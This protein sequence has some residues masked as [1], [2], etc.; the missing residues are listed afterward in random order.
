MTS[1]TETGINSSSCA[2]VRNSV[3][4]FLAILA[5]AAGLSWLLYEPVFPSDY[6]TVLYD[7]IFS[8]VLWIR[9]VVPPLAVALMIIAMLVFT[10]GYDGLVPS[11]KDVRIYT[12]TLS[13]SVVW[14]LLAG[15]FLASSMTKTGLDADLIAFSMR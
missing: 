8:I 9:Y 1:V 15:F 6:I 14:L 4:T 13:S 10:L 12:D 11:E 3:I 5:A 7:G 2:L